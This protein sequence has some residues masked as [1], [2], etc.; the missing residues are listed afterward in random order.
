MDQLSDRDAI[1]RVVAD[2]YEAWFTGDA[3][4]MRASLHPK[5]AKRAIEDSGSASLDLDVISAEEMAVATAE[6]RG[7]RYPRGHD[8]QVFDIDDD[9]ATI[10]AVSAP[11]VEYLHLARFGKRWLIVNVLW[12][13]RADSAPAR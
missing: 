11:Y 3:E 4:R 8:V 10:K 9:L 2:Y 1:E 12:R 5:L 7:T 6:G 13:R